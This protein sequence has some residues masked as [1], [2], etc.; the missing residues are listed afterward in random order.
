MEVWTLIS[1]TPV[2]KRNEILKRGDI[3]GD[4]GGIVIE[5]SPIQKWSDG[6]LAAWTAVCLLPNNDY[7]P[8]VVWEVAA[9]PE[10]FSAQH[11]GYHR[12]LE[13]AVAE[14]KKRCWNNPREN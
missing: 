6:W 14:F 1:D 7:T 11:G 12:I 8:F 5:M 2:D 10:G 13:D 3:V 4:T 9:R